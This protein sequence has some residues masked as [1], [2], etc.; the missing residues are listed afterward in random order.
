[1][2]KA[3]NQK[4]K[5]THNMK[6]IENYSLKEHNTFAV[7]AKAKY[8]VEL[9]ENKEILDE[10]QQFQNEKHFVIGCGS[11]LLF[12]GDFDGVVL[13]YINKK[14][15]VVSEDSEN[16]LVEVA[17]GCLWDEFIETAV[18]NNWHGLENLVGIPGTVGAAPVQNIGAYGVEQK[19]CFEYLN[20]IN[21]INSREKHFKKEACEFDYRDSIFKNYLR[22][23]YII[24]DVCYKLSKKFTPNLKYAN[25]KSSGE[26]TNAR[27]LTT[28]IIEI[29]NAKL[30]DYKVYGNAGSFFKNPIITKSEYKSL[31]AQ[32]ADLKSYFAPDRC[33]KLSAAQLIEKAGWKGKRVGN[34]GISD[35]H[36]LVIVNYGGATGKEI[37]D[38]SEN[39]IN[40]ID[41]RYNI[42]LEREVLV[43]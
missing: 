16:V 2:L 9:D 40:D 3:K 24:T 6:I 37:F 25:L 36:S 19:D 11:N 12:A 14:I 21:I 42:E 22:N 7:E 27:D 30:P 31:L 18:T 28:R 33:V 38:F 29:R 4:L 10:I 34:C 35:I 32:D 26:I 13:S 5:D 39:I 43:V 23:R 17:A 8:Y 20:A 41:D 1:M 15:K